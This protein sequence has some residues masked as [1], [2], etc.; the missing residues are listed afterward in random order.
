[1]PNTSRWHT[2]SGFFRC[3]GCQRLKF[4]AEFY[5]Y[6]VVYEFLYNGVKTTF[7]KLMSRC[8]ECMK[9]DNKAYRGVTDRPQRPHCLTCTCNSHQ[10]VLEQQRLEIDIDAM[11]QRLE[12][13]AYHRKDAR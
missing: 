11:R 2:D 8:I 5:N 12:L 3:S 10:S 7:G 9:E 1:M 4:I 13:E 6:G